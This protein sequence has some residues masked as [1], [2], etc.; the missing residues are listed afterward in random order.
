M[1]SRSR[2]AAVVRPTLAIFREH[3]NSA[4]WL[5]VV[6]LLFGMSTPTMALDPTLSIR[7]YV[8]RSWQ[9]DDGLPQ[10]SIVSLVQ[11]DDGYIWFGT[12]DGLCRF[13][14]ARITVFSS[15]NTPAFHSN[16][17][18][19]VKKGIE[20]SLW[21]STDDGLIQYRNGDFTRLTTD[22][23]L[24]TNF[25]SSVLQEANGRLWVSTGKGF[26]VREPGAEKFVPVEGTPR[27]PGYSA[28]Y[29]RRGRL[30]LNVGTLNRRSGSVLI[31]AVFRDAPADVT[32]TALYKDASGDIWAGTNEGVYRLT[33]D[34]FVR[35]ADS[36]GRVSSIVMDSD[37]NLW[38][39]GPG[40]GLARWQNGAW[41]KYSTG[42]GLTSEAV[43]TI[44][45]D[46]DRNLWVGTS[47]GGLNSFYT[48]KFTTL[49]ATE[50]LPSDYVYTF[51]EDSRG[52][53]WIGTDRG[54]VK[55]APDGTRA[56]YTK[57]S[58]L[59]SSDIRMLKEAPD[60]GLWVGNGRID[61]I[62]DGKIT[63]DVFGVNASVSNLVIDHD[64]NAWV[65]GGAGLL[66]QKNRGEFS[67]VE[68]I[69][70]A[71]VLSMHVDSG[72][73]VLV[74]TRSKGLLRY[75]NGDVTSLAVKEGLSSN[76]VVALYEDKDGALWIG[77]GTGGLNRWKDGKLS[78]FLERDGLF[79]NKVY[80]IREDAAG[81]LWMGS[82]RGIW[83]VTKR[84]LDAFARGETKS[85]KSVAYDRGDGLRSFSISA[86]GFMNPSSWK[87]RD[88][89]L[90]FPTV[91]GVATIDPA[92]IKINE[93]PPPV[94]LEGMLAN[95]QRVAPDE[96]IEAGRRDFEFRF[97]AM[98]FI[99]PNQTLFSYK[100]DGYDREWSE[101]DTRRTAYYTNV[102]PGKYEFR[103]RAANSDGVWNETGA[104]IP[105]TL[106]AYF[107]QTWW[108]IALCI[109]AAFVTVSGVYRLKV[110]LVQARARELEATVDAR[111]K[112]LV[113]AKDAAEKAK[114]VAESASRVKGE[115]LANMSH[116]IRTPMNGVIGMTDLLL[117][118]QL[119][120]MQR[121]YAE[122]VR[123]SAGSLLTV[124]NDI[125]DFSKVE[126]GKLELESLDID[127]RD[128][129]E[130]VA[131]LLS[132]PAHV[133]GVEVVALLDPELPDLMRGDAGR[134]RQIL[135]NLGGNAVKFTAK[136]EV[137]IDCRVVA[138]D[139][140]STLLRCEIRDTGI[141]I[142]PERL[143][144]LF[145][146]FT[147]V[148]SS[149]TR[150]FGGTG[151]GLSIVKRLVELMGGETGVSSDVG[152]GS[153]F[154]FTARF[155]A[156][157]QTSSA[158]PVPPHALKG[159]RILIVDDN[160]TNRKVIVGQL[161]R[162]DMEPVSA[163][164]SSEALTLMHQ[165]A[166]VGKPYEIALLDHQMPGDDGVVLGRKIV[167]DSALKTT[168][169]VLLTSSGQRGEGHKFAEIGFAGYLLKPVS[170][171]DLLDCLTMVMAT[172][173][174]AWHQKSRPIVTGAAG[175]PRLQAKSRLLLAEDN[176]VNQKVACRML[177][178]LGY[179]VDTASDGKA[180]VA[181]WQSGRYELIL[182]DC[183]MPEMDGYEATRTIRKFEAA[184]A[185]ANGTAK[186]TP[187]VALT[188]DAMK[189]ADAE[190]LAAGMDD[191][192]S[193]PI[194][195]ALLA[196]CLL[197]WLPPERTPINIIDPG[198]N[199]HGAI[200]QGAGAHKLSNAG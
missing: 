108:F 163:S 24:S 73:D 193:K 2:L 182:M 95:R 127:V 138:K 177:E 70:A 141:G 22:D 64:G 107:Y 67:R 88:G 159:L 96:A 126:A 198:S 83:R 63:K 69:T 166:A 125:L 53:Q 157:Q 153:V 99:A 155:G 4:L 72:G 173:A 133:K 145:Q 66:R 46:R 7:Q 135:L 71:A 167:A 59:Y 118:T 19:S 199:D 49:G 105:F 98:S 33:G 192:L 175:T 178:I 200:A 146:P 129:I 29:D 114:E 191:Y 52:N 189:G 94:V 89:R 102:P 25:V 196:T 151:L 181:A 68:G 152:S 130:D 180:A 21:I 97:T 122:T 164:S 86:N 45:E 110:R 132:I 12:R 11:S 186:R 121:D 136:G 150:R 184:Q 74:G 131:R 20:G 50:G 100:L 93:T 185:N 154:W 194:D 43:S 36:G 17:I 51:F 188:A 56:L 90:W 140:R 47:G 111:T 18:A 197:R 195:R 124:I 62:R 103:V 13:D 44:I 39:G 10:N 35:F 158:R 77:T 87:T 161:M 75:H 23:G 6:A 101:P 106:R 143:T 171:R 61:L 80:T 92:D 128:T 123:N 168:R 60:G 176:E 14:G 117:D 142:P 116:E 148:D 3:L 156:A 38:I 144:A 41:E 147:Q 109:V 37:G 112:E 179:N 134:L 172:R 58:G 85:I 84:E 162:F 113:V 40:I 27:A 174:E 78:S 187:I 137:T 65:S 9:T 104:A 16:A 8:H 190:C 79:D 28:M 57:E 160:A 82:S 81:N 54:L 5:L 165:A 1:K 26:D 42:D 119:D 76:M 139:S 55:I 120:S 91:Q 15:A 32:L 149:T 183:Q 169:L 30:W 170:Q 31:K 115:F 48:G 34:E